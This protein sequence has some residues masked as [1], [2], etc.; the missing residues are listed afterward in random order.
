MKAMLACCLFLVLAY[1]SSIWERSSGQVGKEAHTS[2]LPPLNNTGNPL[3]NMNI[4][5][6]PPLTTTASTTDSSNIDQILNPAGVVIPPMQVGT[7]GL[8]M[9]SVSEPLPTVTEESS[10][11]LSTAAGVQV[12]SSSSA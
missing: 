8:M 10:F 1:T 11:G 5:A 4:N 12:V 6:L 7:D 3:N 2:I 9:P